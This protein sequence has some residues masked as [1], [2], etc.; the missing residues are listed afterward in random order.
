MHKETLINNIQ[1]VHTFCKSVNENESKGVFGFSM[2]G[3]L[4]MTLSFCP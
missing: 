3:A 1:N 2:T 4:L